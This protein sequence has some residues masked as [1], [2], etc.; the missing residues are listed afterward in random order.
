MRQV[1]LLVVAF[2]GP[3]GCLVSS[4]TEG[5]LPSTP[6]TSPPPPRHYDPP[7]GCKRTACDVDAAKCRENAQANCIKCKVDC[8]AIQIEYQSQ[9]IAACARLCSSTDQ[10]AKGCDDSAKS[11]RASS[12]RN[13]FCADGVADSC[14]PLQ[15]IPSQLPSAASGH[16][17]VCS[18]AE[19]T[20]F[21]EACL[22]ATATT[23]TCQTFISSHRACRACAFGSTGAEPVWTPKNGQRAW[24]NHGLCVALHGDVDCGRA[25][26]A[27]D[28]C[29]T[30]ACDTCEG[31]GACLSAAFDISCVDV[32]SAKE[33]CVKN[34]TV[35]VRADCALEADGNSDFEAL[36]RQMIGLACGN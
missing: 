36:A 27:A 3:A 30:S 13:A 5:T 16:R 34:L 1:L 26:F 32:A 14:V 2:A 31:A 21:V 8:G 18:D 20:G 19:V 9:C 6:I 17:G 12:P 25:I 35:D 29:A 4:D 24:V 11:C 22:S 23:S 28:S 15:S 33:S 7:P 10:T